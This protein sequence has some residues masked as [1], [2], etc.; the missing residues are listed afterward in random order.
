MNRKLLA[1]AAGIGVTLAGSQA[2]AQPAPPGEFV[3]QGEFIFSADRLVP[4]FAFT[5]VKQDLADNGGLT[6]V[7]QTDNTTSLSFLVGTGGGTFFNTPRVGFDYTI[8]DNLTLG[9]DL[10]LYF[11]LGSSHNTHGQRGGASVDTS[12]DNPSVLAFGFAPRVGYILNLSPA[13]SLWLRGGLSYY[14]AQSKTTDTTVNPNVTTTNSNDTFALDFDPQIV[15]SPIPHF[16]FTAG[17]ALDIGFG[18]HTTI[19]TQAGGAETST[20]FGYQPINFSINLGLLGW[21]GG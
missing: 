6:S 7:S 18:G 8:I 5:S 11:T 20:S 4:F 2:H 12:T 14:R 16:A 19:D 10:M 21:F 9:G 3:R 17:P 13:F 15:F 1:V